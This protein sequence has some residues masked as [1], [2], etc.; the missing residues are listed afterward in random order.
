MASLGQHHVAVAVTLIIWGFTWGAVPLSS[1][2][3]FL[4]TAGDHQEP[5][6]SVGVTTMQIAIAGGSALGGILVDSAGLTT[7]FAVAGSIA[8]VAALIAS[9]IGRDRQSTAETTKQF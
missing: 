7:D 1:Q 9:V 4:S 8:V 6:S 3:W 5:A 2:V